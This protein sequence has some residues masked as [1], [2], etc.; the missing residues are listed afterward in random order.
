MP[1]EHLPASWQPRAYRVRDWAMSI[2][3]A[4][5]VIGAGTA[6]RGV[7][8]FGH[9]PP[10]HPAERVLTST[11]WGVVWLCAGVV[12]VASAV[13]PKT[14]LARVS[15]SAAVGLN[16]LWA[17]S[18]VTAWW[19][20]TSSREWVSAVGYLSILGLALIGVWQSTQ[21][22]EATAKVRAYEGLLAVIPSRE[23]VEHEISG[24]AVGD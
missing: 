18:S 15:L 3:P 4:L 12:C 14:W 21:L 9:L 13:R 20:G 23:E 19:M 17:G 24:R 1:I 2:G 7:S 5:V 11:I 22:V 8:Y 10:S 6:A 16:A